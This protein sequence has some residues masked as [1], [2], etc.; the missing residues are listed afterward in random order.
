M[1]GGDDDGSR[2]ADGL[3]EGQMDVARAGRS[4]EDEVVE[5]APLSLCD[6]LLEG[7]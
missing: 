7:V 1:R 6:E 4:V 3:Q 5:V 2:D